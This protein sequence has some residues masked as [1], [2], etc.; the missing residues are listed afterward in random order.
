MASGTVLSFS[1]RLF[2]FG[3]DLS[4]RS[5]PLL[6]Q[7]SLELEEVEANT[8]EDDLAGTHRRQN[9][10]SR[11]L[12]ARADGPN[13]FPEYVAAFVFKGMVPR[14]GIEPPTLRFSVACST[15]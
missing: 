5:A 8:T 10:D 14:G 7:L 9:D 1:R 15:N 3:K 4:E 13:T 11:W 6:D 2:G 12:R